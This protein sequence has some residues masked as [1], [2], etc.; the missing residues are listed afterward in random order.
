LIFND[1][2]LAKKGKILDLSALSYGDTDLSQGGGIAFLITSLIIIFWMFQNI[3][4]TK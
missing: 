1:I 3:R 4:N 2:I